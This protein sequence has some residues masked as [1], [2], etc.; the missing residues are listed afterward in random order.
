MPTPPD[1]L[2]DE[3]A[4]AADGI[5]GAVNLEQNVSP[6]AYGRRMRFRDG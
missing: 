3:L 5:E 4:A 2:P 1:P 6:H